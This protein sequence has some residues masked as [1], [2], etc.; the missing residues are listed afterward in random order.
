MGIVWGGGGGSESWNVGVIHLDKEV[1][2]NGVY[3]RTTFG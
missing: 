3:I 1:P 2:E